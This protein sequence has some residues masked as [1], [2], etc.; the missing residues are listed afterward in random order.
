VR[1]RELGTLEQLQVTPLTRSQ[2]IVGKILPFL[3]IGYIQLTLV[4]LLMR[5]LF[6]IP[7]VGSVPALYLL[8]G[9]Y[10]ASVLGL[11]IFVSTV[12]QTQMQATQM[13]MFFLLPFV[14]LSGYVFPI[15]G[16][17]TFFQYL[18]YLIPANFFMQII[19]GIV[20]RGATVS[21]LWQPIAWLTF[22]T[23][24]IIGFS[25]MRFQKTAS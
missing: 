25:I 21:E 19:R 10:I 23:V 18:T 13:S 5:Y 20:L 6:H 7:I 24:T 17:P 14:F 12:A 22:Y 2:L 16:M 11:G 9:L 3:V 4:V 8:S 15:A 1:E